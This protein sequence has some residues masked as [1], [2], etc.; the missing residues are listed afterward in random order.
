MAGLGSLGNLVM[1]MGRE[2]F[3]MQIRANDKI[4]DIAKRSGVTM[5]TLQDTPPETLSDILNRAARSGAIDPRHAN[6]IN[7]HIAQDA[8][9]AVPVMEY[10]IA[11]I[12]EW[13][14]EANY[15]QTGGKMKTMS[16]DEFLSSVRPLDIDEGSR[17]NIDDLKNHMISGKTLDPLNIFA[18][19]KED[20]RHRAVAAKEL[21]IQEVPVIIFGDPE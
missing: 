7:I 3:G 16:P 9:A 20:G 10:P 2:L 12:D 6:S 11:P 5:D 18:S 14:G 1:S 21:G 13:Y 4:A 15:Q 17:E 8:Q 19:G